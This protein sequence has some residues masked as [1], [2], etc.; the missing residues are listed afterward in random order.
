MGNIFC[1]RTSIMLAVSGIRLAAALAPAAAKQTAVADSPDRCN[2]ALPVRL[3]QTGVRIERALHVLA[4]TGA[5]APIPPHCEVFG[6]LGEHGETMA[7]NMQSISTCD[8]PIIG[9]GAFCFRGAVAPT[10]RLAALSAL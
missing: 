6:I 8:C 9:M 3:V 5:P 7:K 2:S 10:A 4:S 1:H